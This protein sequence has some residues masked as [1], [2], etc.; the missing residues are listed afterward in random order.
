MRAFNKYDRK[1][2]FTL[3]E[4]MIVV[5]IIGVLAA[6]AIFG[7]RRYLASAKTAEA[8]NS[9][10]AMGRGA[11]GAFEKEADSAQS[12]AEGSAGDAPVHSLCPSAAN[13]VPSSKDSIK[14][15]KYQANTAAGADYDQA[16]FRCL[17]FTMNQPQYYMY[18]YSTPNTSQFNATAEGDLDGDGTTS[19]FTLTGNVTADGSSV[20]LNSSINVAEEYE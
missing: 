11:I 6:L 17:K 18:N 14:G 1:R 15:K 8:R 19:T 4:L 10:G 2:G 12:I 5:A 20:K 13:A 16:A 7:V 9:L 3:V